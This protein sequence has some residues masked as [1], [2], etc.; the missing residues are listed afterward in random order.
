MYRAIAAGVCAVGL[1]FYVFPTVAQEPLKVSTTDE[2]V[3]T[4]RRISEKLSS[5]IQSVTVITAEDIS[6]SGQQTITDLLQMQ[7]G[8]EVTGSSLGQPASVSIRG[9]QGAHAVV[10]IDGLR[11]GSATSG[12]T[13]FENI[14]L[15][16][17]ER[18]EIVPGALSGLY[19]S[20]AI[21]GVIQIFTRSGLGTSA[22]IG[23]GSYGTR[24][25]S[26][27]FGRRINDTDI[28]LSL[29]TIE[30]DSFNSTR[31]EIPF[32][33]YKFGNDAYRNSNFSGRVVQHISGASEVGLTLFQSQGVT[34]LDLGPTTDDINRQTQ[35]AFSVFSRNRLTPRW[36]SILRAGTTRDIL[37]TTG[38]FPSYF[39]T[40][41]HQATWQSD[42]QFDSGTLLAG[43]DYLAQRVST[44]SAQY[45]K[46]SRDTVSIFGGYHGMVGKSG[47]QING[48]RDH[49]DQYGQHNTGAI[50]Y[51]YQISSAVKIRASAGTAFR[52]PTF[53]DLYFPTNP[54]LQYIQN[55]NVRPERSRSKEIGA[56]LRGADHVFSVVGFKNNISDLITIYTDP[57]TFDSTTVNLDNAE[58]KGFELSYAGQLAGW[59]LQAKA[60]FQDPHNQADGRML[61]RRANQ[62]GSFS[63]KRR[64]G[65][66]SVGAEAT[67]SGY[68][69]DSSLETT[70]S[71]MH[72]YALL[73][74]AA[75]YSISKDW[76]I[77]GRWNN[78][79]DR[80]YELVQFYNTPRSNM[81]VWLAYQMK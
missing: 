54:A 27:A 11:L 9:T 12:S 16:Q 38:A 79:S 76:S 39:Q 15:S 22:K 60:T 4:A 55:P 33:Q 32:N 18:I 73:N 68:R 67:A 75:A 50:G 56:D 24:E 2:V 21:G 3:V 13:A 80:Q 62:F 63:V 53:N 34:H 23:A 52:A 1:N 41:Q 28:N 5:T 14:P 48:R 37:A 40:D 42:I 45:T 57:V 66:W 72:G 35:N 78:V 51:S 77:N 10:L 61:R 69:Y 81:F 59:R 29:G 31:P 17:I 20:G 43:V 65:N 74:L 30:S 47:F 6:Q 8:L 71:R 19:G 58:I 26:Y 44:D 25:A 64:F 36:V 7:G 70:A 49:S 46:N